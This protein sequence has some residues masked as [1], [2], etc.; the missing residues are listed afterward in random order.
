MALWALI[1]T[2]TVIA[3]IIVFLPIAFGYWRLQSRDGYDLAVYRDQLRELSA[4]IDRGVLSEDEVS[5]ARLEV[6]RRILRSD[7]KQNKVSHASNPFST[8]KLAVVLAIFIPF[9]ALGLYLWWNTPKL[10]LEDPSSHAEA[11]SASPLSDS[12]LETSID[13][14][15]IRLQREP[16]DLEGWA[17]LGRSYMALGRY[18]EA[19]EA[20][21]RGVS[22]LPDNST[23]LGAL[24][25]AMVLSA[26]GYVTPAALEIMSAAVAIN[27]I[28]PA[29]LYY[30]G[31]AKLQSGDE[32]GAFDL[33]L[34]LARNTPS[35]TPWL[36]EVMGR[37]Q[38]VAVSLN[39]NLSSYLPSK[40]QDLARVD[41]VTT[42]PLGEEE[43]AAAAEM[44]A[45]QRREMI[46]GMVEQLAARL[47]NDSSD[48]AGWQRLIR[49]YEVLGKTAEAA[50]ARKKLDDL[51][52]TGPDTVSD[53]ATLR[54]DGVNRLASQSRETA[55]VSPVVR[56]MVD[57]L[58]DRLAS[59][60]TDVQGWLRLSRSYEVLGDLEA[61]Q[62][63]MRRAAKLRPSDIIIQ[64]RFAAMLI[65]SGKLNGPI[66]SEALEI[67]ERILEINPKHADSLF[68][69]GLS[70]ARSGQRE[71]AIATWSKLLDYLD[72]DS[73]AFTEIVRR[74]E[75]LRVLE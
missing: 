18:S 11:L 44:T 10:L 14:L 28:E 20:F 41:M 67:F 49:S 48:K 12:D 71:E 9:S 40:T 39:I 42:V 27:P 68:F 64:S 22:I 38:D 60:A 47:E 70:A 26:G 6:Q 4:D 17:L 52:E 32:R 63:A 16:G 56:K 65:Q 34:R 15:A 61:A 21:Q 58:A 5:A 69:T 72:P 23:L 13:Q 57:D 30:L 73:R 3:V 35:D 62:S 54:S 59:D 66:P 1:V 37:L 75:E 36:N 7:A 53:N 74:I 45:E 31:V 24:G 50:W 8:L 33:W 46:E 51:N 29:S 19:V 2:M 55:N 25:E 43:L